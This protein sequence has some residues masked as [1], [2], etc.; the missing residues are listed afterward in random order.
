MHSAAIIV[1]ILSPSTAL[2]DF[3]IKVPIYQEIDGVQ[4]IWLVDAGRRWVQRW[5]RHGAD[6][7]VALPVTGEDSF[8][9]EVLDARVALDELYAGVRF[10][11][12]EGG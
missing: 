2:N 9:S 11:E 5:H 1:E 4:E 3:R 8:H 10:D 6:W 7:I 12:E